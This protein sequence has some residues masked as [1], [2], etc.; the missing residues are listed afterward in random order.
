MIL[1]PYAPLP[2]HRKKIKVTEKVTQ[3]KC[4]LFSQYTP[5]PGGQ[6]A[7]WEFLKFREIHDCGVRALWVRG[8][9]G[10]GKSHLASAY[11]CSRAY[12]DPKS[13]GLISANSYSQLETSTL[14]ALASFC[15]QFG[16]PIS[17][18][19]AT[20]E[21]TAKAIAA[22]R[23]VRIFDASLFVLSAE[24]FLGATTN[25]SETGRG[26]EVK[27][28][29]GDEYAYAPHS[30]WQTLNGRIG[31][32]PG[33]IKGFALI[34]SSINRNN[35]YNWCYELFDKPKRSD[36]VTRLYKS[37]NCV[38]RD[39]DSLDPDYIDGLT[40]AY[41]PELIAIELMGEYAIMGEGVIC[42]YFNRHQHTTQ[43]QLA[44][45]DLHVS[46][47]FNCAPA[48]SLIFQ[49]DGD[50]IIVHREIHLKDADTFQ[51]G[52]ALVSVLNEFIP[53]CQEA[54]PDPI[55]LHLYGDATG[56]IKTANSQLSN[57]QIIWKKL[58]SLGVEMVKR[59]KAANPPVID[60][61]NSLNALISHN[62]VI[63]DE[64]CDELIKDLE[65]CRY[66]AKGGI[67]KKIDLLR[68]HW[69]DELRY[70][71]HT[72]YPLKFGLQDRV[73]GGEIST[74][75]PSEWETFFDGY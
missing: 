12:L 37:I 17:P 67:D 8:G 7:V 45:G 36:E 48:S 46:C 68:S 63:I 69:L 20:I 71:A 56:N 22:K 65:S 11:V 61:L 42:R 41:T 59:Y 13:R 57:W 26:L 21:E 18:K 30:V 24:A 50:R 16:V 39:N 62:R 31:R 75:T 2:K 51:L 38:T 34:T 15:E 66:D 52:D 5:K 73:K 27:Y 47:D 28:A 44:P 33:S 10:S 49:L 4:T 43:T 19:R 1:S 25:S 3:Q 64:N 54:Y 70:A 32:G 35:P 29:W 60:T 9:V 14:V 55:R 6:T 74:D 58:K 72:L 23:L 40:A 53:Q